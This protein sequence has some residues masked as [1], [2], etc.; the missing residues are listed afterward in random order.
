VF[1]ARPSTVTPKAL[2]ATV[3]LFLYVL[4]GLFGLCDWG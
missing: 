4:A 3:S 2:M 1:Q